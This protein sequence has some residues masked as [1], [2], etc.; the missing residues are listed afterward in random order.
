VPTIGGSLTAILAAAC[1]AGFAAI[2]NTVL[3][4]PLSLPTARDSVVFMRSENHVRSIMGTLAGRGLG[5][6]GLSPGSWC[7]G[8]P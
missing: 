7:A 8:Q 1:V 2:I 4:S 3:M 5:G 6:L